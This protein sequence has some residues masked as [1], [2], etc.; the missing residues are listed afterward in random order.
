MRIMGLDYGSKT[1]GV[2]ISD[3]MQITAQ[4]IE[5]IRRKDENKLRQTLARIEELIVEY[6]VTEIV[7]GLPKNMN[8]TMGPRVEATLEFQEKLERRTGLPVYTWD[9]R[10]TTVSADK[11][12]MEAG[13]RRENRKEY[14]DM[15][16]AVLILQ[17]F[18]DRRAMEKKTEE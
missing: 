16:A 10:L 9:E 8:D 4:G 17:G 7:L 13:I 12:M 6:E 5:I 11:T 2:A 3:A 1:V 14:V 15:I 18:L